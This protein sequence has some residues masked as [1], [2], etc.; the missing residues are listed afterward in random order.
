MGTV[1]LGV[2]LVAGVVGGVVYNHFYWKYSAIIDLRL[3]GGAFDRTARFLATPRTI[4][5][6]DPGALEA[7]ARNLRAAG[8][9]RDPANRVGWY[10]AGDGHIEIHPGPLSHFTLTP[11]G[12]LSK[13]PT[14]PRL[15]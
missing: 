12:S 4:S 14:S 3:D 15:S 8:Y 9:T 6:G 2:C 5:V 10:E 11:H 7:I 1:L 13:T